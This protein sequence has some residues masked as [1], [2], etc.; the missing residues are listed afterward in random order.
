MRRLLLIAILFA[1]CKKDKPAAPPPGDAAV[2]AEPAAAPKA[3]AGEVGGADDQLPRDI[4]FPPPAPAGGDCNAV[5]DR[6]LLVLKAAL[7]ADAETM[8]PDELKQAEAMMPT[9]RTEVLTTCQQ[10]PQQLRDCMLTAT[11]SDA[12]DACGRGYPK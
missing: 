12:L 5:A 1:A 10:Y 4:N 3:P 8:T 11:S 9:M 7:A 6:M 2:A